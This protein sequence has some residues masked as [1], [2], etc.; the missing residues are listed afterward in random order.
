[1]SSRIPGRGDFSSRLAFFSFFLEKDMALM[2]VLMVLLLVAVPGGH[3]AGGAL[4]HPP[5]QA[6][7]SHESDAAKPGYEKTPH[8]TEH[9]AVHPNQ[10][11][12]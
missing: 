4:L 12:R 5:D 2:M 7:Q 11:K 3:M 9:D 8:S 1:M 6:S 10:E